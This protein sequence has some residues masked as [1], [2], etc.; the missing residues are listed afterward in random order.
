MLRP[1]ILLL[2]ATLPA[3]TV[4]GG[5]PAGEAAAV[6]S[7]FRALAHA[8]PEAR[9]GLRMA[10]A[11]A[12][13]RAG[14]AEEAEGVLATVARQDPAVQLMPEFVGLSARAALDGGRPDR[15]LAR[16]AGQ[17]P[18]PAFCPLHV[19]AAEQSG[20]RDAAAAALPCALEQ[21]GRLTPDDRYRLRLAA[22]RVLI[23]R[24]QPVEAL[25]VLRSE[26]RLDGP[27]FLAAA[28]A[29]AMAGEIARATRAYR[30][31]A[32]E[33][34]QPVTVAATASMLRLQVSR[35]EVRPATAY[36]E[37]DK[38]RFAW[39]GG[40]PERRLLSAMYESAKAG[41]MTREALRAGAGLLRHFDL[42]G[43]GMAIAADLSAQMALALSPEHKMPV[44]QAAALFWENRDLLPNGEEGNQLARVLAV[45]LARAGLFE[46]AAEIIVHQARYRSDP[47]AGAALGAQ[48][49]A[50][51]LL[52]AKPQ[53]ALVALD[54]T[55]AANATPDVRLVR[56]KI[57]VAALIAAGQPRAAA[58]VLDSVQESD[59][60]FAA[61]AFW[62]IG[63]LER[64]VPLNE[65]QLARLAASDPSL[66]ELVLKQAAALASLGQ[67]DALSRLMQRHGAQL[68]GRPG[69]DALAMLGGR[70][71]NMNPE[72]VR[73]AL[74]T[75][76]KP[77]WNQAL[78]A[79]A[80]GCGSHPGWTLICPA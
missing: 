59:P 16:L 51:Y 35:Q 8:T 34:P 36:R 42:G 62:Q 12:L 19:I 23:A 46:K 45:R 57:S 15:A 39:R 4:A 5:N 77:R 20:M 32:K 6:S 10:Y 1:A 31:A 43:S 75:L 11:E 79:L 72:M 56:Q 50:A 67:T 47:I 60:G 58:A 44:A 70:P 48:A 40:D 17:A 78:T 76:P 37:L 3:T 25:A 41:A 18:S 53:K 68:A 38:L 7:A 24:R 80:V 64:M 21:A 26:R 9:S 65:Q 71:D 27:G 30:L 28:D 22:A 74:E 29:Q 54:L 61:E 2:A 33:G 66:P 69:H 55:D 52:A 73:K 13:L 14:R 49:A 63:S